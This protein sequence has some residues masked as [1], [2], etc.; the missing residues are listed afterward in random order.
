MQDHP[1]TQMSS[2]SY[3]RTLPIKHVKT[4]SLKHVKTD[5]LKHVKTDSLSFKDLLIFYGISI[6]FKASF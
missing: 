3:F 4:D 1:P 6:V 5:S 2:K